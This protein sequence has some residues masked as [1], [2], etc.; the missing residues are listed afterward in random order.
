[1]YFFSISDKILTTHGYKGPRTKQSSSEILVSTSYYDWLQT[2][3]R[4]LWPVCIVLAQ[5]GPWLWTFICIAEVNSTFVD[6]RSMKWPLVPAVFALLWSHSPRI[7]DST[8]LLLVPY[9]DQGREQEGIIFPFTPGPK[10]TCIESGSLDRGCSAAK[11]VEEWRSCSGQTQFLIPR[12]KPRMVI[13]SKMASVCGFSSAHLFFSQVP[14]WYG[15]C[16]PTQHANI[17][18]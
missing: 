12:R 10:K 2:E 18:L 9:P 6:S 17:N 16:L 4:T 14:H 3:M 8:A 13:K 11:E 1:M 7:E 5:N 15:I